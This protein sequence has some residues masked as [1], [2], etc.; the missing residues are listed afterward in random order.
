M[1]T[2]DFRLPPDPDARKCKRCKKPLDENAHGNRDYHPQCYYEEKKERQRKKYQVG[3]SEKLQFQKCESALEILYDMDPG[4]NGIPVYRAIQEGLNVD[5]PC[6][7]Y[8]HPETKEEIFMF[9][10]YGYSIKTI[11]NI[12]LIFIYHEREL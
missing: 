12:T 10:Q 7:R 8:I 4:K 11:N 3:N 1:N 5:C 9:D 6:R 2:E